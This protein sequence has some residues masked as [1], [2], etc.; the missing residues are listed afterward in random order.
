M[1]LIENQMNKKL[2]RKPIK[3]RAPVTDDQLL[4]AQAM[5]GKKAHLDRG[6]LRGI[7]QCEAV[8][9]PY[10]RIEVLVSNDRKEKEWVTL[11][12]LVP[13][14]EPEP[15]PVEPSTNNNNS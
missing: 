8:R 15:G 13:E 12:A 10:G 14:P 11:A 4:K 6:I 5:V 3:R 2:P 7:V 1:V 9:T